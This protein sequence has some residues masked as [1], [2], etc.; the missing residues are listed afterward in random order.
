MTTQVVTSVPAPLLNPS[1]SRATESFWPW[2][3]LSISLH[4]C[5]TRNKLVWYLGYFHLGFNRCL[6]PITPLRGLDSYNSNSIIISS[7]RDCWIDTLYH[8]VNPLGYRS[9]KF[10]LHDDSIRSRLSNRYAPSF[11]KSFSSNYS[12]SGSIMIHPVGI[13]YVQSIIPKGWQ[14]CRIERS[15]AENPEGMTWNAQNIWHPF[16]VQ[17]NKI[18]VLGSIIIPSFGIAKS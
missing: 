9:L 1:T 7:L 5:G 6:R 15:Y 12:D 8:F 10:W 3:R 18:L 11:R 4:C 17:I 13:D 2:S 16:G 14:V